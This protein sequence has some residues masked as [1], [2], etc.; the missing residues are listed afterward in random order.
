MFT[1]LLWHPTQPVEDIDTMKPA[2]VS[3][4]AQST[5]DG[6]PLFAF[7]F[8]GGHGQAL[9]DLAEAD[10]AAVDADFVWVHLDLRDC[11]AQA[12][13][14]RRPW[15]PDVVDAVAAPIQRGR[16][17][18]MADLVYGHLRDF[19]DEPGAV[20][21]Q[22]GSLCV[23]ASSKLVVTGRRIPLLSVEEVRHR[24][25]V[26]T[27]VPASPFDLITEFFKALN[28]IGEALLQEASECL[29]AMES[30]VLKRSG[31]EHREDLLEMRRSS[32][33]VARDMAY[34]RTAMLELAR[35]RPAP[36]PAQAKA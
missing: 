25:E 9:G 29:G 1:M 6:R 8:R 21:L 36:F 3:A 35:E 26:R 4:T 31:T 32:I 5:S 22:A 17:F 14:C 34:K 11:A 16:L 23:V 20:T 27:V 13:L 15:P 19:R 12:W 2:L 18:M 24:V 28:D 33:R 7:A 10:G 30:K